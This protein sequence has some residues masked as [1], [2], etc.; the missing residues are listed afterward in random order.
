MK[1]N[2]TNRNIPQPQ[3]AN[4]LNNSTT[5]STDYAAMNTDS[6]EEEMEEIKEYI[7]SIGNQATSTEVQKD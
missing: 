4:L 6:S 2:K 5:R 7:S 3:L 1:E